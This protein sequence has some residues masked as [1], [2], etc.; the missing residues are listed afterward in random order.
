M[1]EKTLQQYLLLEN[2]NFRHRK[3]KQI[4]DLNNRTCGFVH[5]LSI[6]SNPGRLVA[7]KEY[8]YSW[9]GARRPAGDGCEYTVP[10]AG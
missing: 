5:P 2:T 1:F 10:S 8:H 4:C 9:K 3:L 6:T 7:S